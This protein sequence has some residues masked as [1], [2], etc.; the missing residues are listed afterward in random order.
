M[1]GTVGKPAREAHAEGQR[2]RMSG[3]AVA[4]G[5]RAALLAV[6]LSFTAT[7]APQRINVDPPINGGDFTVTWTVPTEEPSPDTTYYIEESGPDGNHTHTP[8][9]SAITFTNKPAGF[10]SFTLSCPARRG[11]RRSARTTTRIRTTT[12]P[13]GR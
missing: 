6:V 11:R 7:A 3:R 8:T 5:G 13:A 10:Y 4:G 9:G 12:R 1:E 2:V